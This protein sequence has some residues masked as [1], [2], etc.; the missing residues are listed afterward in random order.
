MSRRNIL[1]SHLEL[2]VQEPEMDALRRQLDLVDYAQCEYGAEIFQML[3]LPA[4]ALRIPG[5]A[6][7]EA[8][9]AS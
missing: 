8:G 3:I 5:L 6:A 2:P 4:L 9:R 7:F 1:E